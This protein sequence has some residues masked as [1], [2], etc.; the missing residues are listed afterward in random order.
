MQN[1]ENPNGLI[2]NARSVNNV[3]VD[4]FACLGPRELEER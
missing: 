4:I 1:K 2:N 3:N